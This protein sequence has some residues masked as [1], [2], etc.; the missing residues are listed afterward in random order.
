[1]RI[2]H[3]NCGSLREITPT[4]EGQRPLP[5]VC[6]CLLVE[7]D[8][9]GLVLVETGFGL[10]D[11]E[12]PE[13]SL[14][15]EFLGWARPALDPD[16]PALRQI[17]S[18][19]FAPEDVR[20]VILT[21]LHRDHTG[22]LPDFPWATVHVHENEYEAAMTSGRYPHQAHWAHQPNW[23]R[24]S[25]TEGER[26]FGFD[27]VRQPIGLPS[28]ILLVPLVGHTPGHIAVAVRD[29]DRWLLHVG[30]AYYHHG[31]LAPEPGRVPPFL[32]SLQSGIETDPAQRLGNLERLRSLARDHLTEV[33]IVSAHDPWEF[34]RYA[35]R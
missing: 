14:G 29:D 32:V 12:A 21:H 9:D 10:G 15:E 5:G 24:Y 27:R 35:N 17:A 8:S 25:F 2:H 11:I 28:D 1:M 22:G 18:L 30:D 33:A 4:G 34:R 19:G 6:H 16:E 7:T 26:W 13:R 20:H 3:L 23:A 31:E